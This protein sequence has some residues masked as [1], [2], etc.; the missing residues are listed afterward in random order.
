MFKCIDYKN[1]LELCIY[2]LENIQVKGIENSLALQFNISRRSVGRVIKHHL[3]KIVK[4]KV[5][6]YFN[7]FNFPQILIFKKLLTELN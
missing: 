5:L 2:Y 4:K 7:G 6:R 3:P 1:Q